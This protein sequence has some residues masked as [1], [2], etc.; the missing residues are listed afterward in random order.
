LLDADDRVVAHFHQIRG[1][2][3]TTH[4]EVSLAK[5]AYAETAWLLDGEIAKQTGVAATAGELCKAAAT[6]EFGAPGTESRVRST[7]AM[8]GWARSAAHEIAHALAEDDVVDPDELIIEGRLPVQSRAWL[9]GLLIHLETLG[10]ASPE[11]RGWRLR[12]TQ[13]FQRRDRF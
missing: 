2:A 5:M 3:I 11:G 1:Q 8:E 10:S 13:I 6:L 12:H 9:R 7:D 4:H